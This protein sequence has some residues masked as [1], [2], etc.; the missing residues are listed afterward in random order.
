MRY[1]R[2]IDRAIRVVGS[3]A[4]TPEAETLLDEHAVDVIVIDAHLRNDRAE[5]VVGDLQRA[6]PEMAF[7]AI[8]TYQDGEIAKQLV[9]R[10]VRTIVPDSA[11]PAGLALAIRTARA[12]HSMIPPILLTAVLELFHSREDSRI[13]VPPLDR[14]TPREVE[15]LRHMVEGAS[16]K[17]VAEVLQLSVDTVRTHVQNM[18]PKLG[19]HSSLGAVGVALRAGLRPLSDSV[20]S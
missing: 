17:D 5:F 6:H 20:P 8:M 15:V 12:G 2:E 10:G 9:G 7:V 1:R 11:P 18:L 16:R 13:S 14:L 19:V 4:T 3:A